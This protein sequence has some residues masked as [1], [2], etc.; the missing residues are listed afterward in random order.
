[1]AQYTDQLTDAIEQIGEGLEGIGS[2]GGIVQKPY[3]ATVQNSR[4][5]QPCD[6]YM[7]VQ[8]IHNNRAV[9]PNTSSIDFICDDCVK[10]PYENSIYSF[11][12]VPGWVR[13]NIPD[14]EQVCLVYQ[15]FDTDDQGFPMVPDEYAHR[16]ALF[17]FLVMK[18]MLAGFEHPNR[19]IN[20]SG[21]EA[22]WLKYCSQAEANGKMFDI[23]NFEAFRRG[24]A[25]LVPNIDSYNQMFVTN[26][27]EENIST[28]YQRKQLYY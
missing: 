15:A 11:S 18:M 12:I 3:M 7:I 2:T 28:P 14:G 27:I 25:R 23:P 4:F 17:W 26:D 10:Q 22:R 24:W 5:E 19:E 13:T 21:A 9:P 16:E 6:L 1:M 8:L 20:Y